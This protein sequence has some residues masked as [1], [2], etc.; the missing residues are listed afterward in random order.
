MHDALFFQ[1]LDQGFELQITARCGHRFGIGA[2][3]AQAAAIIPRGLE[4]V[5]QYLLDPHAG[6][7]VAGAGA[8]P[9]RLLDV[10]AEREF[11]ARFGTH[12]FEAFGIKAP[13]EFDH[14][15][16]PADG[17]GRA[18][19]QIGGGD[20]TCKL[21]VDVDVGGIDDIPH[22]HLSGDR[23][24]GFIDVA[25]NGG[26]GVRVDDARRHMFAAGIDGQRVGGGGQVGSDGGDFAITHQH[27]GVWQHACRSTGP[28]GGVFDQ[29][30]LPRGWRDAEIAGR[31]GRAQWCGNDERQFLRLRSGWRL[32]KH[33]G[34]GGGPSHDRARCLRAALQGVAHGVGDDGLFFA[35]GAFAARQAD[36]QLP[37]AQGEI[38]RA[39]IEN[40]CGAGARAPDFPFA[41]VRGARGDVPSAARVKAVMHGGRVRLAI[42]K[43]HVD[44]GGIR[45]KQIAV[46]HHDIGE[47]ADFECA[48]SVAADYFR[49]GGGECRQRLFGGQAAFDG[50]AQLR[51]E[52]LHV[53]QA[54]RADGKFH[55]SLIER[56]RIRWRLLPM[57]QRFERD[58]DGAVGIF[59]FGHGRKIQRHHQRHAEGFQ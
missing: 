5:T 39:A 16:L 14:L 46:G 47:L 13:A 58:I 8:F 51:P 43:Q 20:A 33:S 24:G 29:Q 45:Q 23:A 6:L 49:R 31:I 30:R 22:A 42:D 34:A 26:V 7:R 32:D 37:G 3:F 27:V 35:T 2:M 17:V 56:G 41:V 48:Q 11:D 21:P 38:T 25:E 15:V 19:Q 55:A 57:L 59:D 9:I 40:E 28:D 50:Q 52:F 54:R 10:L 44:F 53:T 36:N 12:I 1:N 18:V 4:T